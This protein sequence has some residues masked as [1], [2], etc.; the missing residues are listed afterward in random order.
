MRGVTAV[1]I[2]QLNSSAIRLAET[3]DA[4]LLDGERKTVTAS[5]PYSAR[6]LRTKTTRSPP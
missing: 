2:K 5:L 3:V 1:P 6:Q 4:G